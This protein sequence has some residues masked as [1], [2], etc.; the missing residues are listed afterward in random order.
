MGVHMAK[1]LKSVKN[2]IV[3][4]C[5]LNL[6]TSFLKSQYFKNTKKLFCFRL[7]SGIMNLYVKHIFDIK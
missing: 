1:S 3:F 6:I 4:P 2:H 5:I 7:V